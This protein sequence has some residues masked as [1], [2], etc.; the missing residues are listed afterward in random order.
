MNPLTTDEIYT[1][2]MG[3]KGAYERFKISVPPEMKRSIERNTGITFD[4]T[5]EKFELCLNLL[6]HGKHVV[7]ADPY[8]R[9]TLTQFFSTFGPFFKMMDEMSS[10]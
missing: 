8:M 10:T 3:Y 4:D 7:D 1:A 5:M 9:Y 2:L 6:K